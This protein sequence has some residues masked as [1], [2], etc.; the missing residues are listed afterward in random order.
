MKFFKP[1]SILTFGLILSLGLANAQEGD[2]QDIYDEIPPIADA[3]VMRD[4]ESAENVDLMRARAMQGRYEMPKYDEDYY[5][6]YMM[7]RM[8]AMPMMEQDYRSM[9]YNETCPYAEKSWNKKWDKS[10][11]DKGDWGNKSYGAIIFYKLLM[12]VGAL[13]FIFFAACAARKGWE[14]GGRCCQSHKGFF[15]KDK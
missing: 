9:K 3:V 8:N 14:M 11:W 10:K 12:T 2:I 13:I 7:M 15:G 1:L 5:K 4:G 6:K